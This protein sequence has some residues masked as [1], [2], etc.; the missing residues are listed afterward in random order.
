MDNKET[1]NKEIKNTT[2][3]EANKK[4]TNKITAVKNAVVRKVASMG[5]EMSAVASTAKS[6]V[7]KSGAKSG[8]KP[9]DARLRDVK[10]KDVRT[11]DNKSK[12][13]KTR[14]KPEAAPAFE[15]VEEQDIVET[16]D[17]KIAIDIRVIEEFAGHAALDCFGIVGM[18]NV[19]MRDGI[20]KLLTGNS[21]SKGVS[22]TRDEDGALVIDYHIIVAYGVSIQ[23]VVSNLINTVK[24]QIEDYTNKKVKAINVYVEGVRV[25]D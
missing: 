14:E 15:A 17:G 13:V 1:K 23:T 5:T 7:A 3:R 10:P 24:Y 18:C 2:N 9:K 8:A 16:K 22:V 4:E 6:K 20:A 21:I 19:S 11:R 25:I 12:E